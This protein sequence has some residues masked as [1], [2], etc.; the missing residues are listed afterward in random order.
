VSQEL[1]YD[2][3]SEF[4]VAAA[5]DLHKGVPAGD[6][7]GGGEA[8]Q[9]AHRPQPGLEPAMIGYHPAVAVALRPVA[10]RGQQLLQ[11]TDVGRCQR[12]LK[13]RLPPT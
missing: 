1:G 4:I 12:R 10:G 3:G 13:Q 6:H 2:I 9:P 5:E 11:H 7:R 8:F